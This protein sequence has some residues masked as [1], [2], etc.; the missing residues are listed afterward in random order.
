MK[1]MKCIEEKFF[2]F[3]DFLPKEEYRRI[4]DGVL[5]ERKK[6]LFEDVS[7]S[8]DKKLYNNLTEP[9]R[10]NMIPEIFANLANICGNLPHIHLNAQKMRFAIHYMKKNSGINWHSDEGH[11]YAVT[12]YLN[13]NW[14][15]Q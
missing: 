7:V 14:N 11:N 1:L 2:Y 5:K 4:H 10:V 6:L 13:H 9:M 12:Y 15:Q 3:Q 8:W